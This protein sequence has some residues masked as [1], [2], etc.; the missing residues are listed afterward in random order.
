VPVHKRQMFFSTYVLNTVRPT[1]VPC[2]SVY[3]KTRVRRNERN[4]VFT[5]LQNSTFDR[6]FLWLADSY[7][8]ER[9]V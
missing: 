2:C 9:D 5:K 4:Y 6:S 7:T 3:F 1:E 8:P